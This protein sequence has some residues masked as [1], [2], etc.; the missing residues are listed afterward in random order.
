MEHVRCQ[1]SFDAD[2][3]YRFWSCSICVKTNECQ[4]LFQTLIHAPQRV[5]TEQ[6]S[7]PVLTMP[8]PDNSHTGS[9][10]VDYKP[11]PTDDKPAAAQN[12]HDA[13][14]FNL[15]SALSHSALCQRSPFFTEAPP[16]QNPLLTLED[17]LNRKFLGLPARLADKEPENSPINGNQ[18]ASPQK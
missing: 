7:I 10:P 2:L 16:G 18:D 8:T 12:G 6:R 5:A 4:T 3:S 1:R 13:Q 11:S 17:K 15:Q 14:I 9:S